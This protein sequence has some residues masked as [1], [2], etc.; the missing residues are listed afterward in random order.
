MTIVNANSGKQKKKEHFYLNKI[1]Y[2][3]V[4]IECVRI[5]KYV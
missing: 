4:L 2:F 3:L 1:S 5:V